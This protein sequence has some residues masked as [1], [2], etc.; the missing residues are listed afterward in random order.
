M[1]VNAEEH[2]SM[3]TVFLDGKNLSACIEADDVEGWAKCMKMDED[4]MYLLTE[5]LKEF[6]TEILTGE[7][8]IVDTDV[9]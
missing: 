7:I 6:E 9:K 8:T 2:A 4:G 1:R 3:Y 5:D